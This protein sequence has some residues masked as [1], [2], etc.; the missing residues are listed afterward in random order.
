MAEIKSVQEGS[1]HKLPTLNKFM[2]PRNI[3]RT[4]PSFKQLASLYPNFRKFCSYDVGDKVHLDFSNPQALAELA[5]ALLH[6]DF[7]LTVQLPQTHLVPTIPLRLNYLL[8]LQDIVNLWADKVKPRQF[9]LQD[10][11]LQQQQQKEQ[12]DVGQLK[13]GSEVSLEQKSKQEPYYATPVIGFD[14]GCGASCVYGLLG[15]RQCDF[16]MIASDTDHEALSVARAN[17]ATSH[18]HDRVFVVQSSENSLFSALDGGD[19]RRF[20]STIRRSDAQLPAARDEPMDVDNLTTTGGENAKS[21]LVDFAMCNP[22]FF[23]SEQEA[24]SCNK[25]KKHRPPPNNGYTGRAQETVV[26][27]GEVAFISR[28]IQESSLYKDKIRVFSTLV[29]TAAD[30]KQ[31]KQLL[32]AAVPAHSTVTEFCQ[33]R[34]MRWGVAWSWCSDVA[35]EAVK[36]KK[37]SSSVKPLLLHWPRVSSLVSCSVP[38]AWEAIEAWLREIKLKPKVFKTSKYFVGATLKAYKATWKN[39]RQRR[40]EEKK[41]QHKSNDG[42]TVNSPDSAMSDADTSGASESSV[43]GHCDADPKPNGEVDTKRRLSLHSVQDDL[44]DC[45]DNPNKRRKLELEE[46][47]GD[48]SESNDDEACDVGGESVIE[49]TSSSGVASRQENRTGKP[50]LL[51]VNMFVKLVNNQLIVEMHTLGGLM[52][53]EG[54]NQVL[55]Y[56]RNKIQRKV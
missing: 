52:G 2:H 20:L 15:A 5:I 7:Q 35:L 50:C 3:Y 18:L 23:S 49:D 30:V 48:D 27:G 55:T 29:G 11:L 41:K 21:Y 54:T 33:G 16:H 10:A 9:N 13:N 1:S 28:M 46:N 36:S 32:A 17:V 53:R 51:K 44:R 8:W 26:E 34:T 43:S 19:A 22:P 45:A 40:R 25:T 31:V 39:Q 4:P 42:G 12:Y 14:I 56:L 6:K 38:G 37:Q 47:S 24:H